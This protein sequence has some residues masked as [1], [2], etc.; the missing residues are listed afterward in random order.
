MRCTSQCVHANLLLLY[1]CDG[2]V[3]KKSSA[4]SP[5]V[6]LIHTDQSCRPFCAPKG[7]PLLLLVA[8]ML[9]R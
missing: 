6:M 5:H 1:E 9:A 3:P 8:A 7:H 2:L 4:R